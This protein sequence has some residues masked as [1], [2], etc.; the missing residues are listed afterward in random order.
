MDSVLEMTFLMDHLPP[1]SLDTMKI[2]DVGAGYGR[3]LHRLANVTTN[4]HLFGA[5][6]VA[7]STAICRAYIRHLGLDSR[8]SILALSDVDALLDN[9]DLAINIHSFSEMSLEVVAWWI[10]WLVNRQVKYLF[11]VPTIAGPV[12][13][14]GTDLRP[15]LRERGFEVEVHRM[16]Y[17]DPLVGESA[18]YQ[19]N[20]YLFARQ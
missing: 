2:V 12:L 7:L 18:L 4:P 5:D 17:A 13:N 14:D 10:D 16:K 8:V 20:Y 1:G 11:L 19:T 6:G 3:L 15:F 9:V